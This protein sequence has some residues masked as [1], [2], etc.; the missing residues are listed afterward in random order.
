MCLYDRFTGTLKLPFPHL[1]GEIQGQVV[2]GDIN[3]DG[4]VEIVSADVRGNVA[5]WTGDGKELWTVHLKSIVA[6]VISSDIMSN[7]C[8]FYS[9][10]HLLFFYFL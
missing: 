8:I 7:S 3:D 10:T 1:M 4:K 6:Q 9:V 2:A 5:A